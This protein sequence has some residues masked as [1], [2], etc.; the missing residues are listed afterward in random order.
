MAVAKASLN[1]NAKENKFQRSLFDEKN[2]LILLFHLEGAQMSNV[3]L[4][5]A[6]LKATL[7]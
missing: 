5:Y 2:L 7:K 4:E 3:K 6:H 1:K